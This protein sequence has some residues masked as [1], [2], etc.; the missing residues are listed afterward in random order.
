MIVLILQTKMQSNL[1]S[2]KVCEFETK[3]IKLVIFYFRIDDHQFIGI[4]RV[5]N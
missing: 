4:R 3:L 5:E 1:S 2:M